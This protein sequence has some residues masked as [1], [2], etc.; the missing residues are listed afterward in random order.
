MEH[1]TTIRAES[2]DKAI[3]IGLTKLN[4]SESEANINIISEGKKGLF[5]FGKQD[6]IVEI[7]KNA[8]ISELTAEIEKQ[9]EEKKDELIDHTK[10]P[11]P[12]IKKEAK[13][14]KAKPQQQEQKVEPTKEE[15]PKAVQTPVKDSELIS[16]DV[17]TENKHHD[18]LMAEHQ[19][20]AEYLENIINDYGAKADITVERQ[21]NQLIF[22]IETD[23]SGLII[24]KHGKIINSLQV[25]AQIMVHQYDKRRQSVILNIGDYRNRRANVLE[26]IAERTAKEVLKTKHSVVLD[27]L[28]SYERKQIHAY[29]SKVEHIATHSEGRDPNRYLVVEY[30]P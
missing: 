19:K 27:P 18:D 5:G 20:V 17:Q 2:V 28:P 21:K 1:S 6:A 23:K 29:L 16:D 14:S 10:T 7:S 13:K 22:N 26:Q 12:S 25:L 15:K 4:I 24:G 9:V 11:E 3:K 8:S 30:K